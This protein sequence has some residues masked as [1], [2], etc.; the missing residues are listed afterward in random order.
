MYIINI[1]VLWHHKLS[2]GKTVV[3]KYFE[4]VPVALVIQH[5]QRKHRILFCYVACLAI[6]YSF[7]FFSWKGYIFC[8]KFLNKSVFSFV[9]TNYVGKFS[10]SEKN[11]EGY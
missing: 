4:Y 1:S 3:V 7:M 6:S 11:S 2:F 9:S 8:L 10:H 5:E